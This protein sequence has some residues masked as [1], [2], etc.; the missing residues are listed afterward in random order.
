LTPALYRVVVSYLVLPTISWIVG[1]LGF[2][3]VSS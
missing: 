2:D 3:M 1:V